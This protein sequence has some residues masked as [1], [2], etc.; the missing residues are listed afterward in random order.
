MRYNPSQ[1]AELPVTVATPFIERSLTR[2]K[3]NNCKGRS[4]LI[5]PPSN[6]HL[7]FT[8]HST[9][10]PS[11]DPPCPSFHRT[12]VIHLQ[13]LFRAL[14]LLL[15]LLIIS[16]FTSHSTT[17]HPY[18]S[19]DHPVLLFTEHLSSTP[20]AL[21]APFISTIEGLPSLVFPVSSNLALLNFSAQEMWR[22]CVRPTY[23]S[24]RHS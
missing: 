23:H 15:S 16:S 19:L 10:R 22:W 11:F 1:M 21:S 20:K 3:E 8:S 13:T 14:Y 12:S 5:H 24:F 4:K 9:T 18:L 2:S 7:P 17:H 6:R